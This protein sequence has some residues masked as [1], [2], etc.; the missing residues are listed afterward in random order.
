MFYGFYDNLWATIGRQETL[1]DGGDPPDA[2]ID[3][4]AGLSWSF[5]LPPGGE[6]TNSHVI[7][8][9]DTL[10][11]GG[12]QLNHQTPDG[13]VIVKYDPRFLWSQ[14]EPAFGARADEVAL[15]VQARAIA[16]LNTY[17]GL[18]FPV[19][20]MPDP[21]VINIRCDFPFFIPSYS[22]GWTESAGMINLRADFIR[23]NLFAYLTT[24]PRPNAAG[25]G[26]ANLVDHELAHTL[27][28]QDTG[29]VSAALRLAL[30]G[31]IAN[32]EGT[33]TAIEDLLSDT[34][35]LTATEYQSFLSLAQPFLGNRPHQV[36]QVP[37]DGRAGYRVAPFFEYLGERFGDQGQAN[38]ELRDASML[39]AL[40]REW[41][42][43]GIEK[44]IGRQETAQAALRDFLLTAYVRDAG[45]RNTLPQG[46]RFLDEIT[47]NGGAAGAGS[48]LS[49]WGRLPF[50]F[51]KP[52]PVVTAAA[53]ASIND[54]SLVPY[55]GQVH[56]VLLG[57]GIEGVR[58]TVTDK[59]PAPRGRGDMGSAPLQLAFVPSNGFTGSG[60]GTVAFDP[61]LRLAGPGTGRSQDYAVTVGGNDRLAIVAVTGGQAGRYDLKIAA[62]AP[63]LAIDTVVPVAE[64]DQGSGIEV[65]ATPTLD[66]AREELVDQRRSWT[67]LGQLRVPHASSVHH[68]STPMFTNRRPTASETGEKGEP[69]SPQATPRQMDVL[70]TFVATGGSVAHAAVAVGIRPS[71]VK[72]HLADLRARSGL[73]TEQLIYSGRAEGWLVVPG[74]EPS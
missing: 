36:D 2:Y 35:D 11:C 73:T 37:N 26:W 19:D 64:Q 14:K 4:S 58:I 15:T 25:T 65:L 7:R 55:A 3:N 69:M 33:A 54:A 12:Q 45:N 47:A 20:A 62:Q 48:G 40:Y 46:Y 32:V 8:I 21:V 31:D 43:D 56:E 5:I 1:V 28:V 50:P 57:A 67:S 52:A 38:L 74:L 53:P 17:K 13:R 61:A 9:T 49:S 41:H 59:R 60:V 68:A 6:A 42:A 22:P 29:Q 71:T 51:P 39:R 24:T 70:A 44:A 18:G 10:S 63:G 30:S 27:Q 23:A 34:D 72:R 66:G 16:T